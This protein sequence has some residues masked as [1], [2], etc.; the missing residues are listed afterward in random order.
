MNQKEYMKNEGVRRKISRAEKGHLWIK[1][2][3]KAQ[4]AESGYRRTEKNK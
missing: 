1:L 3:K 4:D 2:I